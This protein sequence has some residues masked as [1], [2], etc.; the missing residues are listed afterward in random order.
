MTEVYCIGNEEVFLTWEEYF[1]YC[2][3]NNIP[4]EYEPPQS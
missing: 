4:L 1:A 2:V 3:E